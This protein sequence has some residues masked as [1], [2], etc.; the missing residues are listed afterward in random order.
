MGHFETVI[1]R[2]RQGLK[3][4]ADT[5]PANHAEEPPS[6]EVPATLN[7]DELRA[8]F[9]A[10]LKGVG[11]QAIEVADEAAAAEQT[12]G[13]LRTLDLRSAALAEGITT[14]SASVMARLAADGFEVLRIASPDGQAPSDLKQRLS[15]IDVG[16]VEADYA[17]ASTGALAMVAAPQRPRSVSL[18][19]PVN[20]VLLQ[21]GRILPDLAAVLR[22]VGPQTIASRPMVL[23]TGPSRTAD[24]EKRIVIGVHGPKELYVVIIGDAASTAGNGTAQ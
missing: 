22:A 16:I 11:A 24:I 19:P 21:A 5:E 9:V 12:A 10:A 20:I 14:D 6:A 2:I 15:A 7:P 17:I 8:K 18:L 23:V 13:L 4:G 1:S 3:L